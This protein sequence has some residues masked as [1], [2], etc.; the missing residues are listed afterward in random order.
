MNA[1]AIRPLRAGDLPAVKALIDSKGLFPSELLD[2]MTAD[3]LAGATAEQRWLVHDYGGVQA[4][5]YC[6]PELMTDGIQTCPPALE[7]RWLVRPIH[8]NPSDVDARGRYS[9]PIHPVYPDS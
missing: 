4:V 3:Y 6:A 2:G 1:L 7:P 5:A 9:Q 8:D